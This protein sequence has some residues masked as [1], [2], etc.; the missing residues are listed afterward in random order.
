MIAKGEI[1]FEM[2]AGGEKPEEFIV[3]VEWV[4]ILVKV[5]ELILNNFGVVTRCESA[6][7]YAILFEDHIICGELFW[8]KIGLEEKKRKREKRSPEGWAACSFK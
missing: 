3:G 2:V 4:G 1:K 7:N 8:F 5:E 6:M